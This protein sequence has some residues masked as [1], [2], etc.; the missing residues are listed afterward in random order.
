MEAYINRSERMLEW[1]QNWTWIDMVL[2]LKSRQRIVARGDFLLLFGC[3]DCDCNASTA[4]H[5]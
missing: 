2:R 3:S 4:E 5:R 1:A